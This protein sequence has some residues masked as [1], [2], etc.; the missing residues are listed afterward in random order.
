MNVIYTYMGH[1]SLYIHSRRWLMEGNIK[2][3]QVVGKNV[4]KGARRLKN[5]YNKLTGYITLRP[6]WAAMPCTG[7]E[8][9][10]PIKNQCNPIHLIIYVTRESNVTRRLLGKRCYDHMDIL[11]GNQDWLS[12][13]WKV[14]VQNVKSC[15]K[16]L[17]YCQARK[18]V[19]DV[20]LFIGP[21]THVL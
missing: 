8:G 9:I 1:K 7:I 21:N 20:N 18:T 14:Q 6:Y 12:L 17:N 19:P 2:F 10:S 11:L 16:H 15:A 4:I 5:K 3:R 13:Q